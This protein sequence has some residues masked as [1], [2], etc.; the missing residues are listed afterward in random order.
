[1]KVDDLLAGAREATGLADFGDD[2]LFGGDGWREAFAR[3]LASLNDEARLSELG[4]GIVAGELANYLATRLR[5]VEHH[6]A[7]PEIRDRDVTPPVVIIG[8]ARTGTTMLH[9][10]LAQDA[11]HRAPLTWEVDLPLPPPRTETYLTD[12]RIAEVDATFE[13]VDTFIPEFRAVHQLGARLA[14]ECSR[15]TGGS[16]VSVIFPTQYRVPGYLDWVLHDAV[17]DGHHAA[18]YVWH[19]RYLELLQSEHPGT[20]WLVKSPAHVWTLPQLVAEYPDALLVQT[21]R[22][23]ARVIASTASMLSHLR[24]LYSDDVRFAEL[25]P[26]FAELILDGLERTAQA[27]LD[28]TVRPAQVADVLFRDLMADPLAAAR[29]IYDRFGWELT[30]EA[31]GRMAAFLRDNAREK[32]G[33]HDYTFADTGLDLAAVRDRTARYSEHFAVPEEVR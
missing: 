19:R 30:D 31:E 13:L 4:R 7:H 10:V 22:D 23:P 9:D 15:I 6:R 8:Q 20:R 5:I 14:Q 32:W 21:H 24:R 18:A 27:R 12:P 16:F 17:R 28:G 26:E 11:A 25:G 33:G 2:G 29:S 3:L 1:M